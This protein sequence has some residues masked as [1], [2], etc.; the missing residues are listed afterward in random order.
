MNLKFLQNDLQI[1][2]VYTWERLLAVLWWQMT[3]MCE[4]LSI[5]WKELHSAVIVCLNASCTEPIYHFTS[6]IR[7]LGTSGKTAHASE[8]CKVNRTFHQSFTCHNANRMNGVTCQDFLNKE[9][10]SNRAASVSAPF[11]RSIIQSADWRWRKMFQEG[12]CPQE[13]KSQI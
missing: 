10:I 6:W 5:Y 1:K 3:C 8:K 12:A 13:R 9:R 11:H 2:V 4:R 7:F